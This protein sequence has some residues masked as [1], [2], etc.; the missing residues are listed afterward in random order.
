M[1]PDS[2]NSLPD[3]I[4]DLIPAWRTADAAA[5]RPDRQRRASGRNGSAVAHGEA[6]RAFAS[7]S[8]RSFPPIE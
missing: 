2:Y 6:G 1:Q 3:A 4:A 8:R 7:K 5:K